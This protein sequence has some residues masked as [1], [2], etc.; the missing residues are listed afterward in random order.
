MSSLLTF[1]MFFADMNMLKESTRFLTFLTFQD[2]F[3]AYFYGLSSTA[4]RLQSHYEEKFH[5]LLLSPQEFLV[6]I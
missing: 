4:S 5:F 6:L 3:M 2:F 1:Y